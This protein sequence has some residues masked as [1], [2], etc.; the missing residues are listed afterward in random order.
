MSDFPKR[1]NLIS[2]L[3]V[4][5]TSSERWRVI[6]NIVTLI[7]RAIETSSRLDAHLQLVPSLRR[8]KD[9]Q[10]LNRRLVR[11]ELLVEVEI[12]RL[13]AEKLLD[14]LERK[15]LIDRKKLA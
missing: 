6:S 1:V 14:D 4:Y 11:L 13:T 7:E 5:R 10:E 15:K 9:E 8:K 3:V 12:D 2:D